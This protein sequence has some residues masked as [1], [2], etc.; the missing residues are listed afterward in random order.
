LAPE[1]LHRPLVGGRRQSL[2]NGTAAGLLLLVLVLRW[3]VG[4]L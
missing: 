3:K 2:L 4:A 1:L